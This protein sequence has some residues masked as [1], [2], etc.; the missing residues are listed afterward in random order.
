M[1]FELWKEIGSE[2]LMKNTIN[3]WLYCVPNG[4]S[5]VQMIE[6]PVLCNVTK[7]IVEGLCEDIV[8]YT[9]EKHSVAAGLLSPSGHYYL[10]D[11]KGQS[12]WP[13]SDPCGRTQKNQLNTVLN[14]AGWVYVR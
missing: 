11:T 14:P 4:G 10:L 1:S 7:V 9:F 5:L 13:V 8:P 6:G 12:T 2:F 3:N